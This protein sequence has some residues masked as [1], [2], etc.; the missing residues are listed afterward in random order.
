MTFF[1][2]QASSS[3]DP[4]GFRPAFYKSTW[5][6]TSHAIFSLFHSF[7]DHSVD[8]E[9]INRS[10]IIPLPKKDVVRTP[11]DFRP[12]CLQNCPVKGISKVL[13]KR[14]QPLIPSLI[15]DD[16]TGFVLGRNIAD[17]FVYAA[18]LLHCCYRRDA[19]TIVLKL[20]FHKAF[21]YVNWDS[22]H[23]ILIYRGFSPNWCVWILG[24]LQTGKSSI[25]LNGVPGKWITCRNGLRQ[26]DPLSPYLFIIVVDVLKRLLHQNS[27][28]PAVCHPLLSN[29]PCP[30]LQYADDTLIFLCASP[31]GIL[32]VKNALIDFELATG[33]SI[34]FHKTT[35]LP[36]GVSTNDATDLATFLVL[37]FHPSPRNTLASP[38]LL[39]SY[40]CPT[41]NRSLPL[42][43]ATSLGGVL[44]Y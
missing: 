37:L 33:L 20:D 7:Y 6:T 10:Y 26:G 19:P 18:D 9:H 21:D 22:L 1:S 38:F 15:S 30:I 42:V 23:K 4:D 29:T 32:A 5:N 41:A 34:N 17:N 14:L 25:L 31:E 12:I 2:M 43:I 27:L 28:L 44:P 40:L 35:F 3:P 13:T 39:I 16:Q 24:L 36:I 8:L 11:A